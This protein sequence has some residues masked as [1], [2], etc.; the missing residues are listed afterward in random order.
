[1][2]LKHI[3]NQDLDYLNAQ[4]R[5]NHNCQENEASAKY[6]LCEDNHPA[7]CKGRTINKAMTK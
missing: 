5:S 4:D 3:A 2:K 6:V 7:N 1:M